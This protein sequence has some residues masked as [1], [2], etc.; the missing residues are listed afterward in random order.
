MLND[1]KEYA[2]KNP[3]SFMSSKGGPIVGGV[4]LY[5]YLSIQEIK[6]KKGEVVLEKEQI[7]SWNPKTP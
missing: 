4:G 1:L 2:K 6:S 5:Y 3:K 7:I